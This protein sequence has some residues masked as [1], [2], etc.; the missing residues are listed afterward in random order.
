MADEVLLFVTYRP[1]EKALAELKEFFSSRTTK[2]LD[3]DFA[4]EMLGRHLDLKF[5]LA[6]RGMPTYDFVLA[7]EGVDETRQLTLKDTIVYALDA[8]DRR[9]AKQLFRMPRENSWVL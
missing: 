8:I 3:L 4:A 6:L 2:P 5:K 1:K 7:L 9:E